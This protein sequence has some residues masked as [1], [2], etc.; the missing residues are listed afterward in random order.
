MIAKVAFKTSRAFFHW[1]N[2]GRRWFLY[3][4]FCSQGCILFKEFSDYCIRMG[5]KDPGREPIHGLDLRSG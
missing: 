1:K 3:L 4:L 5:L 2:P